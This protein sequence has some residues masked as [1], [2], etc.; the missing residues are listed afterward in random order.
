MDE[1]VKK[2]L[3]PRIEKHCLSLYESGQHKHA[4]REAMVQVE[5]ALRERGRLG[6]DCFGLG[7]IQRVFKGHQGVLLKVPLGDELQEKARRYF[8]AVFSYYRNYVAHD[9]TRIDERSSLR[10]LLIASELLEMLDACALTLADRGGIEGLVRV[11]DCGTPQ[12][13]ADLLL[14]L[15]GYWTYADS[16]DGLFEELAEKGFGSEQL[17]SVFDIG[18]V[19]MHCS[20]GE[21]FLPAKD[22]LVDMEDITLTELGRQVMETLNMSLKKGMRQEEPSP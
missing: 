18:L 8:E 7:L 16:Y 15:D 17:E 4:A 1:C 9:G 21:N 11:V 20:K 19:E 12:R 6:S 10:I 14:L 2:L 22:D 3:A 5:L 13:V